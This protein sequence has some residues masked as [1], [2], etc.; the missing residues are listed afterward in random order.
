MPLKR[1]GGP[2]VGLDIGAATIKA[3]Q[4]ES[5]GGKPYLRGVA[6]L[7]TP[8]DIVINGEIVNPVALGR[9][10]K[11]VLARNGIR[12]NRV[13]SSVT[14]QNSLVVRIIEVP[15]MTRKELA[16]T[17]QWEVERHVPF[18]AEQVVMDYQPLIAPEEVPEGQ[19]MEVLLAVVQQDAVDRHIEA[20]QA[21]GLRPVAVDIEPL[22]VARACIEL[23]GSSLPASV[24]AVVDIGAA[25]TE[26]SIHREGQLAFN[27]SIQIAGSHLTRS[28]S[29]VL[30]R[31]LSEAEQLKLAMA[32]I[33]GSAGGGATAD[34]MD[35]DFGM[36]GLD[37]G[38]GDTGFDS[39]PSADPAAATSTGAA[40]ETQFDIAG[41]GF[42][43]DAF[44]SPSQPE[45]A[46][47][48]LAGP[49]PQG[50]PFAAPAAP[51]DEPPASQAGGF[52]NPFGDTEIF[53]PTPG[54]DPF[55]SPGDDPFG[56]SV[57]LASAPAATSS[58]APAAMTEEEYLRTQ[59]SDAITPV[60]A[61]LLE[62]LRRSLDFYRN[63]ANGLGA[64]SI[65]L[66]GG[67]ARLPGLSE[68]FSA[69]LGLPVTVGN[70]LSLLAIGGKLDTGYLEEVGP[71][72]GVSVGLAVREL[73]EEPPAPRKRR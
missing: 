54:G 3:C 68:Y 38:F 72:F 7:D 39:A 52:D 43:D 21:A 70:P 65:V 36:G 58:T 16:D 61:E 15:R 62:E 13:V 22:A 27:R 59:I 50:D 53:G 35:D 45:P 66:V 34:M 73:I 48:G 42:T 1:S 31:P 51:G 71:A 49:A 25:T 11:E 57:A 44:T 12:G 33:Q 9:A 37:F 64:Q 20:I 19:N 56:S 47:A 5:R 46:A 69:N 4:I 32:G 24:I 26:I 60:L 55:A 17:M 23:P 29:D 67:T 8:A 30:Q 28:I 63:R 40:D 6:V 14:G 41:A 18:A 10:I 2:Y